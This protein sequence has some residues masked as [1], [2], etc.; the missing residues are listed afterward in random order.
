M[1]VHSTHS[2]TVGRVVNVNTAQSCMNF[3]TMF[4][5]YSVRQTGMSSS[6]LNQPVQ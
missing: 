3:D 2:H 4:M 1:Y 6:V 5:H